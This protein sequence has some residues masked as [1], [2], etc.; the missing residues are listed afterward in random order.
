MC[1]WCGVCMYRLT[2]C[3]GLTQRANRC[4]TRETEREREKERERE[5]ER[6]EGKLL[7]W[8]GEEAREPGDTA[9]TEKRIFRTLSSQAHPKNNIRNFCLKLMLRQNYGKKGKEVFPSHFNLVGHL[10]KNINW[11]KRERKRNEPVSIQLHLK[12]KKR[13]EKRSLRV[14]SEE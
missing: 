2:C 6:K 8:E 5:R 12:K 9:M 14:R 3:R 11:G 7:D 1:W 10:K 4:C 13:K